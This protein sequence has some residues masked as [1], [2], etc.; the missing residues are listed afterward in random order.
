MSFLISLRD[1]NYTIVEF[2]ELKAEDLPDWVKP[3]HAFLTAWQLGN[4]EFIQKTSGSTAQ[5]KEIFIK[6][7]HMIASAQNTIEALDIPKEAKAL[8]CIDTAYIGGKMMLIRAILGKWH[9][10]LIPPS[11]ALQTKILWPHYHFAAMVPLQISKTLETIGGSS[12]FN[13]F[14]QII[15]GGAAVT[16]QMTS[17]LSE[18]NC[19]FYSTFG[20]TETVSHI[21]LKKLNGPNKS[22]SFHVIGDNQISTNQ[23]DCLMIKGKVTNNEWIITNDVVV[24]TLQGFKWIGRFDLTVNTGGVK[25]PIESTEKSILERLNTEGHQFI[26]WKTPDD[27][28]GEMLIGIS[29]SKFFLAHLIEYK[30]ELTEALPKY[31]FPKKLFLVDE[32]KYTQSGKIDRRGTSEKAQIEVSF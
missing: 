22:D 7:Q 11:G 4:T 28:L 21:A 20:M 5:A 31:H 30:D 10:H 23:H 13:R 9:L 26:L 16:E 29:D 3:T 1:K 25:V 24:M 27:N 32:I 2:I 8:L 14:E 18:I 17:W 12:I 6:K 19:A 15:I